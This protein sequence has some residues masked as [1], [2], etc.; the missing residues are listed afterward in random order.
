MCL[1]H[2]NKIKL[3]AKMYQITVLADHFIDIFHGLNFADWIKIR[4]YKASEGQ[5]NHIF[6]DSRICV[7]RGSSAK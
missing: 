2:G 4:R 5:L 3:Q 1:W 6:Q 7:K